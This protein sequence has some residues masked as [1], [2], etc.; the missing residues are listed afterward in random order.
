LSIP[1][2]LNNSSDDAD[3]STQPLAAG[4]VIQALETAS[5]LPFPDCDGELRQL[6]I[7]MMKSCR[8]C[9]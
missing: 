2:L 7:S 8:G 9:S 4:Q 1:L 6:I 3:K 5:F